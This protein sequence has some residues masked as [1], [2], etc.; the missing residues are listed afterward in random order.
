MRNCYL[1]RNYKDINGA[2]NK[3]KTD[4][5]RIMSKSGYVNVGFRQTRYTNTVLAFFSHIGQCTESSFIIEVWRPPCST[6][7]AEEIFYF[8]M[9]DGSSAKSES[10]RGNTRSR[11]FPSKEA[12]SESGN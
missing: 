12:Y 5:E 6:V 9:P 11:K 10:D 4:I 7:S 1:S 8:C 3:A 2:G